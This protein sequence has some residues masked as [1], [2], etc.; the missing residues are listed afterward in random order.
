MVREKYTKI[1]NH[2]ITKHI[3][4]DKTIKSNNK[5]NKIC[6][7][8][9][10]G[11]EPND[12]AHIYSGSIFKINEFD[13][14]PYIDGL[15]ELVEY[16]DELN[17]V[18]NAN[19]HFFLYYDSSIENEEKFILLKKKILTKY[20]FIKLLKYTCPD[21]I[22]DNK[23]K[24]LFGTFV[25]FFPLFEKQYKNHVRS[26]TD[27]DFKYYSKEKFIDLIRRKQLD[28]NENLNIIYPVG[29]EKRYN[30][31]I[32]F[33]N[34]VAFA[35]IMLKKGYF[36][37]QILY[38]FLKRVNNKDKKIINDYK[39][40]LS[41]KGYPIKIKILKNTVNNKILN[42][43]M[44]IYSIDEYFINK[45]LLKYW[46]SK[47]NSIG[48]FYFIPTGY[49]LYFKNI[50]TDDIKNNPKFIDFAKELLRDKYKPNLDI[51]KYIQQI[52]NYFFNYNSA[53]SMNEYIKKYYNVIHFYNISIKYKNILN[54]DKSVIDASKHIIDNKYIYT[55]AIFNNEFLNPSPEL[56]KLAN[57]L[58]SK[59]T[60]KS[61][62]ITYSLNIR[63]TSKYT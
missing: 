3:I 5:S 7:F 31:I 53:V 30:N 16:M 14:S 59:I 38:S 9:T 26:I 33:Q 43:D 62:K 28:S 29:Y 25:R 46:F 32:A 61:F 1:K 56:T 41:Y 10:E 52:S 20:K 23:H 8:E 40:M 17:K 60:V 39:I 55:D 24:G 51:N 12:T 37:I 36:P 34:I 19:I 44:F 11:Y 35:N 47:N 63:Y 15:N 21:Y 49:K 50:I 57:Y 18:K 4:M 22:V 6:N 54:I 42:T 48:I 2:F 45:I 13:I 58:R 27:I